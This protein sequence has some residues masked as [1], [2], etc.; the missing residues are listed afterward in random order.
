M[1]GNTSGTIAGSRLPW[2]WLFVGF[3]LVPFTTWQT[4]VPLTSWLAPL[5]L[6]RFVRTSEFKRTR[7]W[8]VFLA[9]AVGNLIA[10]RGLKCQSLLEL[11]VWIFM[12]PILRGLYG[13]LPYAIDVRVGSRLK[14]WARTMVFPV[15]FTALDWA[16]S[17]DKHSAT[18]GSP[19]YSQ[20]DDLALMQLVSMT[21]IWGI[22]FLIGWFASTIN[23]L[24]EQDFDWRPVRARLMVYGGVLLAVIAYGSIRL[25]A[26]AA[27][28]DRV[29]AASV[30]IDS[31]VQAEASSSIDWPTF[32]RSTDQERTAVRAKTQ[33][34]IDMMLSR[35]E[36]A[37][38][39]G[40]RIVG[41]QEACV[42]VME[43]DLE[44]LID[45]AS[46]L[47]RRYGA[48]LQISPLVAKRATS[49]PYLL[50]ESI[51]IDSSGKVA[52]T[53]EKTYPF[54]FEGFLVVAGPGRLPL[55]VTP[56]GRL[57]SAL[58]ND[59]HFPSLIRQAG[60]IHANI[61]IS[62][63]SENPPFESRAVAVTRAIENGVAVLRPTGKGVSLIA[64]EKGHV[65]ARRDYFQAGSGILMG[66]IPIHQVRTVYPIIGDVFAYLDAG[67]LLGLIVVA[68]IRRKRSVPVLEPVPQG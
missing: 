46:A 60:Q 3:L 56:F 11:A 28:L 27:P 4:V 63:Y 2:L 17:L 37:L 30:T 58:C 51:L 66:T 52:W 68:V 15:A 67:T 35:T 26:V 55:A 43:E 42:V 29:Q 22:T 65:L 59:M 1:S 31:A 40:A 25:N 64:D 9:F 49:W 34:A 20:A 50:N 45:Q 62:P 21:G 14:G 16:I 19:A 23:E 53:Y 47:A 7:V 61:L 44:G 38:G 12:V 13:M 24:W 32:N 8:L 48:Y 54:G 5:F 39:G 36:T 6:L 33:K 10:M 57:T 41:W 18:A